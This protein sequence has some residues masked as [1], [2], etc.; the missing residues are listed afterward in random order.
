MASHSHRAWKRQ[1]YKVIKKQDRQAEVYAC[2]WMLMSEQNE[3]TFRKNQTTFL[4]YWEDKEPQFVT[5]YKQEYL[6]R[7]GTVMQQFVHS[8]S[9]ADTIQKSGPYVTVILITMIQT[10]TC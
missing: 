9:K 10:P 4:T 1:I 8:D 2:L 5:Y 3:A 6:K 7:A